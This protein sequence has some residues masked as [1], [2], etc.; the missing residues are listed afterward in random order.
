MYNNIFWLYL[1]LLL[2]CIT[3]TTSS[4]TLLF[5]PSHLCSK[6]LL[7]GKGRFRV[8]KEAIEYDNSKNTIQYIYFLCPLE[9]V[10]KQFLF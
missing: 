10:F 9:E 5:S 3:F 8:L 6:V 2:P 1:F 4:P 7:E